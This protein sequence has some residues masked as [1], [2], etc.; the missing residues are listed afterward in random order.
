MGTTWHQNY[1]SHTLWLMVIFFISAIFP[2]NPPQEM[3]R[4]WRILSALLTSYICS[5]VSPTYF[6]LFQHYIYFEYFYF[7]YYSLLLIANLIP[8]GKV[9]IIVST[10]GTFLF[11]FLLH[12]CS[13][14]TVYNLQ[15]IVGRTFLKVHWFNQFILQQPLSLVLASALIKLPA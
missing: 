2:S 7:F 4:G 15:W 10:E 9:F 6:F 3:S 12:F 11:I 14:H 1:V 5:L 8:S 13:L